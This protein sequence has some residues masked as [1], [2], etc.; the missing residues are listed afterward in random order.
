MWYFNAQ[1]VLDHKVE[2]DINMNL[3]D[4]D[5]VPLEGDGRDDALR[6]VQ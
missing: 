3:H 1:V 5:E 6:N 4:D 2:Q